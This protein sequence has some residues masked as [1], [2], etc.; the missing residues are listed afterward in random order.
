MVD[1]LTDDELRQMVAGTRGVLERASE[2]VPLHKDFIAK[3]C[4]AEVM[5]FAS[6]Q[7]KAM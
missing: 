6:P 1:N 5:E 7:R 4:R 3:H 2:I